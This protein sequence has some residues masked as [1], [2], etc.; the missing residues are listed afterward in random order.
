MHWWRAGHNTCPLCNNVGVNA[1]NDSLEEPFLFRRQ[2][3]ENYKKLR[4]YSRKKNAPKSLK[5]HVCRIKKLEERIKKYV[6]EN[7]QWRESIST[8]LTNRQIMSQG[9][10]KK[11]YLWKIKRQ[12]RYAKIALGATQ[13]IVPIIIATKIKV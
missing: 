4:A 8:D 11:R 5:D 6:K 9:W 12:L 13:E 2:N 10:K 3:M 7:K 1:A